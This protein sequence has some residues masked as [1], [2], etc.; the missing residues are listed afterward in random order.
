[1]L[2]IDGIRYQET[3][4]KDEDELEQMV[5]EHAQEIF[6]QNSI[7]FDKKHKLISLAGVGAIPDGL[8]IMFGDVPRWHIVEVE[9]SS[10]DPYQ[11]VVPQVD[12]FINAVG[13]L[14][15]RN[16]IIEALYT[17]INS[18]EFSK[19]KIKEIIGQNKDIHKFLS[20]L[21]ALTPNITI[22]I[23]TNTDPLK[24]ALNKYSQKKVVEFKTFKREQ[25]EAVHA[26]LFEPVYT[27]VPKPI[28]VAPAIGNIPKTPPRPFTPPRRITLKNLLDMGILKTGQLIYK[29]YGGKRYEGKISTEGFIELNGNKF[30]TP[31]GAAR[32]ITSKPVDGWTWWSTL[33]KNGKEI[34]LDNLREEYRQKRS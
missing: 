29:E 28:I 12:R 3:P 31:S 16:K 32:S 18:D 13:N 7:F 24:E 10:H 33:D 20:D 6:G 4:P 8:A 34:L 2:L 26:H 9:L 14:N 5:I 19:I 22:V 23:E 11:H 17:S 1:M 27:E 30:D 25:A 21:I 15:T